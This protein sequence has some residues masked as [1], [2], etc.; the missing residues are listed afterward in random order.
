MRMGDVVARMEER[1]RPRRE[2]YDAPLENRRPF[3][4]AGRRR[5]RHALIAIGV[6]LLIAGGSIFAQADRATVVGRDEV[7]RRFE[8]QRTAPTTATDLG[9][10]TTS[11]AT[12]PRTVRAPVAPSEDVRRAPAPSGPYALPAEGVF[13]YDATGGERLS[14]FG[15]EHRYPER[16]YA[17]ITR[18]E[19][20]G[21]EARIDVIKEHT[22]IVGLC[23]AP[24]RLDQT[25]QTRDLTFFGVRQIVT[26][27][28]DPAL[29]VHD[30]SEEPGAKQAFRCTDEENTATADIRRTFVGVEEMRIGGVKTRAVH[31]HLDSVLS[32]RATGRS[33]DDVWTSPDT[34]MLYR[35]KRSVDSETS[36]AFGVDARYI[37]DAEFV[38]RSLAPVS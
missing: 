33:T 20:C 19:G 32:G 21:W 27:R 14:V 4:A 5:L 18:I 16:V 25:S 15:A 28:C 34:G 13:E 31:V 29:V 8:A 24:D 2:V 12:E 3:L 22:D 9:T 23:S 37:E 36:A 17:T 7:V 6:V 11:D 1:A 35:W 26:M 38:L 30:A 10:T